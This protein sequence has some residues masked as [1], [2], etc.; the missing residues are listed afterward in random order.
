VNRFLLTLV[1]L[2]PLKLVGQQIS[3]I[4]STGTGPLAFSD[5]VICNSSSTTLAISLTG[6]PT[7]VT[8]SLVNPPPGATISPNAGN[9]NATINWIPSQTTQYIKVKVE[10]TSPL[11]EDFATLVIQPTAGNI[12]LT[13]NTYCRS[14]APFNLPIGSP[15]GGSYSISPSP[16]GL[17]TNNAGIYTINPSVL[18]NSNIGTF[19]I[20]YSYTDTYSANSSSQPCTSTST[21]SITI[22]GTSLTLNFSPS[23][24]QKCSSPITLNGGSPSGGTYSVVGNPSAI[25]GNTLLPS[26]LNVG[27][28]VLRYTYTDAYGCTTFKDQTL[29]VTGINLTS[30]GLNLLVFDPNNP[31]PTPITPTLFSGLQTFSICTGASSAFFKIQPYNLSNFTNYTVT[32]GDGSPVSSGT[33]TTTAPFIVHQYMVAGIYPVT[34]T[35][36]DLNGCSISSTFNLFFGSTQSL[37]LTTPG[38]TTVC[39]GPGIDSVGFD[40]EISNWQNDPIGIQY[41]FGANDNSPPLNL[42][43]P[44]VDI[45]TGSTVHPRLVYNTSTQKLF[46]RHYFN[47]SSC[48]YTS[49]LGSATYNNS[50]SVSATKSSPCPGSQSSAAVAPIVVSKSPTAGISAPDSTCTNDIVEFNDATLGGQMV[51]SVNGSYVCDPTTSGYWEVYPPTGFQIISGPLG[52]SGGWPTYPPLWNNGGDPLKLKF[53]KAGTYSIVR[54]IGL[55]ANGNALCSIDRDTHTICVDTIP[56]AQINPYLP[57]SICSGETV[58]IHFVRDSINCG[59]RAK[60][61]VNVYA[62]APGPLG[63]PIASLSQAPSL[64]TNKSIQ[65]NTIGKYILEII[66]KNHCG[67]NAI[68]DTIT[69]IDKPIVNFLQ[70]TVEFCNSSG[71]VS[72]GLSPHDLSFDLPFRVPT[73]TSWIVNPSTGWTQNGLN[74]QGFPIFE[75]NTIGIYTVKIVF[76][77]NCGFD[78]ASQ[79]IRIFS[80]PDPAWTLASDQG[81]SPFTPT[82]ATAANTNGNDTWKLFDAAGTLLSTVSNTA[83]LSLPYQPFGAVANPSTTTSTTFTIRHIVTAGSG[84]KDSLTLTFT[85]WPTPDADFS[86]PTS[87]CGLNSF[88]ITNNSSASPNPTYQWNIYDRSSGNWV[89]TNSILSSTSDPAPTFTFPQLQYPSPDKTYSIKLIVTSSDNCVDSIV[90]PITLLAR[91][92]AQFDPIANGCG[93]INLTLNNTSAVNTPRTFSAYQWSIST[94]NAN[95]SIATLSTTTSANPTLSITTPTIDSAVY[96]LTLIANDNQGCADTTS[97][98]FRVYAHPTAVFSTPTTGVCEPYNLNQLSNTSLTGFSNP[99]SPQLGIWTVSKTTLTGT[100]IVYTSPAPELTP[101]FTLG[102]SG[103]DDSLYTISLLVTNTKNC[104]DNVSHTINVHPNAKAQINATS[105]TECAPFVLNNTDITSTPFPNANSNVTWRVYDPTSALVYGPSATLNYTISAPNTYVWVVLNATSLHGCADDVDSLKFQTL[106]NPDAEFAVAPSDTICDGLSISLTVTNPN[107]NYNYQWRNS[108]NNSPFTLIASTQN[109]GAQVL[110][111]SSPNSYSNIQYQLNVIA[112][113]ACEDSTTQNV[114]V[115]P[116]P[117]PVASANSG[118][119]GDSLTL[120]GSS[121]N[122]GLIAQWEWTIAGQTIIGKNIKFL[123]QN[124]GTY[125]ISL[126]TTSIFGCERFALDTIVA[127]DYPTAQISYSSNCGIDTVC[128]GSLI[129][130]QSNSIIG[131]PSAPISSYQWDLNDDGIVDGTNTTF[132]ATF[133]TIGVKQLRLRVVTG[134]NCEDDT[135]IQFTVIDL[136][137]LALSFND[138]QICGPATPTYSVTTSGVV[139]SSYYKLSAMSYGQKV[140]INQWFN[141]S[142]ILPLLQPNYRSDTLYILEGHLYNCCG[143]VSVDDTL[144][145]KTPPVAD[146]LVLPDTGCSPLNVLFQLDNYVLGNADSAFINFGDGTSNSYTPTWTQQG[147]QFIWFWGAINHVYTNSG[148]LGTTYYATISVF[149]DCGDSTITVPINIEPNTTL[150]SFNLSNNSGCAPLTVNFTNTSFNAPNY[151]WCFDWNPLTKQC[152][153]ASSVLNNPTWTFTNPGT[154]NVA[155][156]ID[157]NCSYDTVVQQVTVLPSPDAQFNSNN[158]VCI[159]D[160]ILFNSTSSISSGWIAGY[161]WDFGDGDT[162]ILQNPTH[163]FGSSGAFIVKLIVTSS[164]G[165]QDSAFQTINILPSPEANFSTINVCLGDTTY[166]TNLSTI[167]GGSISGV[168]WDFG[169]GNLSTQSNPSHIYASPGSYT[170]TLKAYSSANCVDSSTQILVVFP[171]P[172]LGFTPSLIAG[173]SCSVPQ[174]YLFTNTSTGAQSYSWDFDFGNNPGLNTSTLTTPT[175]TYT[176]PGVYTVLLTGDNAFDCRD[177]LFKQILVRDGVNGAFVVLPSEGCEPLEVTFSDASIYTTSLDTIASIIW[178]FGDGNTHTQTSP[179]WN[180]TYTFGTYGNF[181]PSYTIRMTSGC[182]SNFVGVPISIYPKVTADFDINYINLNTRSFTNLSLSVDPITKV[183]WDFGD[184]T[185]STQ[186]SPTHIY[187]PDYSQL[188]SIRICLYVETINGCPDSLCKNIWLWPPHLSVPNAFAPDLEYIGE[189][190][191][192]LPKGHSLA[193]YE[194]IIYD[195]WGNEVW[196]T[197]ELTELGMPKVGWNGLDFNGKKCPMGVYAWTIR[198]VFD[199]TERWVGQEDIYGRIRPYGTLT[200]IR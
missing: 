176:S 160:T 127:N 158:N 90:K 1:L 189:D 62:F 116:N 112:G 65:F 168:A 36:T 113:N 185:T 124:P 92:L 118:C 64:D 194:L 184:G 125:P 34:L 104:T 147:S 138:Q 78:T 33:F 96:T 7:N 193:T 20:T 86:I 80:N 163:T 105:T 192:F 169:D 109:I 70:D 29:T 87:V 58:D 94:P 21:T 152:G 167:N 182:S 151:S 141:T 145:V 45:T 153:G 178:D 57:D 106:P 97:Q 159:G 136:P 200:L 3:I 11:S 155:L 171:L 54:Y 19:T 37:G 137:S 119:Y 190:N 49:S 5:T 40:F 48:T 149:N 180:F 144:I 82:V 73:D 39:L 130:F 10:N 161:A 91:P 108:I 72:I 38:N 53:T 140:L 15:S 157:N 24:F 22:G 187:K 143:T 47:K 2:L 32:W 60:Y 117:S 71:M 122:D 115:Y 126:K 81:C 75:F 131:S 69:V 166:F 188:D 13:S 43:A 132:Q 162:S 183:L 95:G 146:V 66:A 8:W 174:T 156:F 181:T 83:P 4:P 61:G 31:Q 111:N 42:S 175:F 107:S 35:L 139:D 165:C 114:Y 134:N 198:A 84:C 52:N 128:K 63:T 26:Q 129:Q 172:E 121:N 98:T 50:F 74:S 102:N 164:N 148:S 101:N 28:H 17:L 133:T 88:T 170:V 23:T 135:L 177:S 85:V 100:V 12:N 103:V 123:F 77:N 59:T 6:S 195:A 9:T 56:L 14:D 99:T 110:T 120:A 150:A 51:Y 67:E 154:Y 196:R 41:S 197:N 93:P 179:P 79:Y 173:D 76:S 46:Y 142:P 191:L 16:S 25:S 89:K 18:N 55:T 186:F 30:P 44:L 68:L 27:T 199:N